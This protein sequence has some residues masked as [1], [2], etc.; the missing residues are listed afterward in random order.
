MGAPKRPSPAR[1]RA[2]LAVTGAVALAACLGTPALVSAVRPPQGPAS[3]PTA[4]P[5][6][7]IV[8]SP[9]QTRSDGP[10]A[11]GGREDL[12]LFTSTLETAA[13]ATRP[14]SLTART[15]TD[16]LTAAGFDPDAMER[17]ADR[18]SAN[19]AS[20]ALTVSVRLGPTCL[21]GQY[22]RADASI[23]ANRDEAV[24]SGTCLVGRT[25]PVE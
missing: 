7:P 8:P 25:A 22:V 18:T 17:T 16:A 10:P 9:G 21:I 24:G 5:A 15:L 20:P 14:S 6:P 2:V 3:G 4:P 11:S 1:K 23:V 19:L 13:R 12:E